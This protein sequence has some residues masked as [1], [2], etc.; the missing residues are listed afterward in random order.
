MHFQF[1]PQYFN[2]PYILAMWQCGTCHL[3]K[4]GM[5]RNYYKMCD[6]S[7]SIKFPLNICCKVRL[8]TACY[9]FACASLWAISFETF[10]RETLFWYGGTTFHKYEYQVNWFKV[11]EKKKRICKLKLLLFSSRP[12]IK[13]INLVKAISKSKSLH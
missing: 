2:H 8:C 12:L 7:S 6:D 10:N 9:L 3:E 11:T 4:T 13:I 1:I 5:P